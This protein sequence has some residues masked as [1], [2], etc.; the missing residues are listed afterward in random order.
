MKPFLSKLA[1]PPVAVPLLMA[2]VSIVAIF[3]MMLVSLGPERIVE[4]LR[5][6]CGK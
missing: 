4:I 3:G 1:E 6:C 5:L 2:A